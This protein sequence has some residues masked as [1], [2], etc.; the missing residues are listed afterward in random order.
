MVLVQVKEAKTRNVKKP[1]PGSLG[2]W[3]PD[4][5]LAAVPICDGWI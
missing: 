2:L 3:N 1:N 5:I 4:R